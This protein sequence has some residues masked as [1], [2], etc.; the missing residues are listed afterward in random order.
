MYAYRILTVALVLLLAL[1]AGCSPSEDQAF[2]ASQDNR[3]VA[4]GDETQESTA[5]FVTGD[6]ERSDTAVYR[7]PADERN[8]RHITLDNGLSVLLISD[9]E[10]DKA[11][12]SLSVNVGSFD[13]PPDR[14]GL[15]HF[16]EHMLF[17]GTDRYPE[18]GEYQ[19]FI[20]EHGGSHN[21]YTSLE[22]TNYFFEVDAPHLMAAL[23]RFSRFFV[24]PLFNPEFVDRE[25]NAVE[26]EYRLRLKDDGRREWDVLRELANPEHPIGLFSVGN[27]ETLADRENDAVRN[28]LL[29]FYERYYSANLMTLAVLGREDL[30]TLEAAVRT[31]FAEIPDRGVELEE[32]TT[33][34]FASELP[35]R[36]SISPEKELRYLSVS[37]PVPSVRSLWRTKPV[38]FIAHLLGHEG[39]GTLLAELKRLGLA[40]SL[41]AGL[42]FDSRAGALFTVSIGLTEAGVVHHEAITAAFFDWLDL[43]R[44]QGLEQWRY[45]EVANLS[46]VAFRFAD[47]QGASRTVQNLSTLMHHYPVAEV[48]RG[49]YL[50]DAFEPK[51]IADVASHLRRDNAF[52]T[53]V[54]H[55]VATDRHSVYYQTPYRVEPIN[56]SLLEAGEHGIE[57]LSLALPEPNEFIP[58]HLT[59]LESEGAPLLPQRVALEESGDELW[60]YHDS[61]FKTPRAVFEARIAIPGLDDPRRET[62]LDLYRALVADQLS[63]RTYPAAQAG[64]GFRIDRWDNGLSLRVQGYSE[65][66]AL[67]LDEIVEVMASPD[68]D[69][70]RF[71]RIHDQLLRQWRNTAKDWPVSQL[72]GRLGPLLRDT[73]LPV[74]KADILATLTLDDVRQFAGDLYARSHA[75]FYSGGNVDRDAALAMASVVDRNLGLGDGEGDVIDVTYQVHDL[76]PRDELAV[77]PVFVDHEDNAAL[78]FL[79]GAEDNLQE[80]AR[81][82]LLQKLTEAP[83]YSELRT[84]RQ[85]GYVVGNGISP[86]H[87]VPGLVFYVQSPRFDSAQLQEEIDAFLSRFATRLEELGEEDLERIRQAVLAGI[88]EQPKNLTELVGRHLEALHLGYNDFDFRPQLAT[89]I[90]A[91]SLDDLRTAYQRVL[92]DAREGLWVLSTRDEGYLTLDREARDALVEGAYS[93]AQ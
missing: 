48:L 30:D 60:H 14:E 41:V 9:P 68:W 4:L 81:F 84:E 63:S 22:E 91:V 89:A 46:R 15:A 90:R 42:A 80:R 26:S 16:L 75:R 32:K 54:A 50:F 82:A 3:S 38:D 67:L 88:E 5:W 70:A 36:I 74:E 21:A 49:P 65:K 33:P 69:T 62:L 23:D 37:F 92:L 45:E 28:D 83:F 18:P 78:L 2:Q 24:A 12:A 73:W 77:F 64:L 57:E 93:Y 56:V 72:M 87:R 66:Q 10:T 25:R 11:A 85:L 55:G 39:E 44:Q 76:R 17:L 13:N 47:K 40:E 51:E 6:D 43:V 20:S 71:E 1:M 8:Y 58:E 29:A 19:A 53:L 59:V 86:M 7:S 34:L 52:V 79:Q 35:F 31:R 61:Q 27:L